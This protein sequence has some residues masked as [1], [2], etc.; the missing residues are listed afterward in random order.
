MWTDFGVA[1]IGD[2]ANHHD[3]DPGSLGGL[4]HASQS[5]VVIIR[6]GKKSCKVRRGIMRGAIIGQEVLMLRAGLV[7]GEEG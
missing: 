2:F 1:H 3:F 4:S 5:A 6:S 7:G